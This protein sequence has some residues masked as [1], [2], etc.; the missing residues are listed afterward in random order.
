M[1]KIYE[2]QDIAAEQ[3]IDLFFNKKV[4]WVRL[5]A[6]MQSG[7]TGTYASVIKKFNNK[8]HVETKYV[9]ITPVSDISLKKQ[10]T[11]D[12]KEIVGESIDVLV[13][14]NSDLSRSKIDSIVNK[15]KGENVF[16]VIDESH[17]GG[18]KGSCVDQF[19]KMLNI[20]ENKSFLDWKNQRVHLLTVSATPFAKALIKQ[21]KGFPPHFY[22]ELFSLRDRYKKG[23]KIALT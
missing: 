15:L 22:N 9:V 4:K 10:I 18:A 1:K 21:N 3:I 14:H 7:K 13:L 17:V 12:V 5:F 23:E 8:T 6:Q 20:S 19:C 11:E 2:N 16:L